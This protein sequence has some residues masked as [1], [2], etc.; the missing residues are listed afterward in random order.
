MS[1]SIALARI[2]LGLPGPAVALGASLFIAGAIYSAYQARQRRRWDQ[3]YPLR[4]YGPAEDPGAGSAEVPSAAYPWTVLCSTG[5]WLRFWSVNVDCGTNPGVS[6]RELRPGQWFNTS[7]IAS[8][9]PP[10]AP[11]FS[12]ITTAHFSDPVFAQWGRIPLPSGGA[13]VLPDVWYPSPG[14]AQPGSKGDRW[15]PPSWSP[16]PLPGMPSKSGVLVGFPPFVAT[17]KPGRV[18]KRAPH[19]FVE[20]GRRVARDRA[21]THRR[22]VAGLPPQLRAAPWAIATP[23][24]EVLQGEDLVPGLSGAYPEQWAAELTPSGVRPV[25]RTGLAQPGPRT[26]E[27]KAAFRS[28]SAFSEFIRYNMTTEIRDFVTALWDNIPDQCKQFRKKSRLQ[29]RNWRRRRDKREPNRIIGRISKGGRPTLARMMRDVYQHWD[30]IQW[31]PW[32]EGAFPSNL[33]PDKTL[34]MAARVGDGPQVLGPGPG[35]SGPNAVTYGRA[36]RALTRRRGA[37]LDLDLNQLEDAFY[38][39]LGIA[40]KK[41]RDRTRNTAGFQFGGGLMNRRNASELGVPSPVDW[42]SEL[43]GI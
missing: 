10:G 26:K 14:V 5:A 37:L 12:V 22:A 30:C 8:E 31:D 27:V 28:A 16:Y 21:E 24:G 33:R 20:G 38:G 15:V 3:V 34:T 18:V 43:L 32:I 40:A 4:P 9:R 29:G 36:S 6:G 19:A 41:A 23:Q 35:S 39:G 17:P 42:V 2:S 25:A 1:G 13:A 11:G 7:F